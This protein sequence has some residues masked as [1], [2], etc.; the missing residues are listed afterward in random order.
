MEYIITIAIMAISII[1]LKIGLNIHI[2]D[3]KK[4]KEIGYD[5][6][7]NKIARKFPD[8]KEIC[9]KILE[10]LDNKKVKIEEEKDSKTSLYI[11]ISDKIIIANIKDTF[12]RIQ[13]IAHECLHSVQS[14]TML[15]F[16]FIFSNISLLYFLV[17]IFLV[18]FNVLDGFVFIQIYIGIGIISYVIKS[19]LETDAMTK[20]FYIAKEYMEETAKA[21]ANITKEEVDILL[22]NI[23]KLN[24]I[25]ISLTNFYLIVG[26]MLKIIF[27]CIMGL[28]F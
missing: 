3:I 21:S 25:G 2:K 26:I 22:D 8:N 1:L 17:A 14:R 7:L 10:K 15:L 11:A 16:N 9:T 13:T 5:K 23:A 28:I 12:T 4:I 27:L 20:A 18:L 6:E 24:K 19:Y